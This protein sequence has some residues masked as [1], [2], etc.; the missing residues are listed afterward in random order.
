MEKQHVAYPYN[1]I[2]FSYK[3]EQCT[4]LCHTM[5]EPRKHYANLK[6][7]VTKNHILY[8]LFI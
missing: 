2:V 4:D 8:I 1:R 3:R 7:L 6:K 5:D